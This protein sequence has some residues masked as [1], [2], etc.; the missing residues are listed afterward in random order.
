VVAGNDLIFTTF[1]ASL[2]DSRGYGKLVA[3]VTLRRRVAPW[4]PSTV[5]SL[6]VLRRTAT[7]NYGTNAE[8]WEF[9]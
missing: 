4:A 6:F 2:K 8:L 9:K 7:R 5:T 1:S 3:R